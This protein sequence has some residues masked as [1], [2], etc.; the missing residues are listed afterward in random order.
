[1]LKKSIYPILAIIVGIILSLSYL[2]GVFT[3]LE[4]FLEDQLFQSKTINSNLVILSIDNDSIQKIGQWPWPRE[5]F[6]KLLENLNAAPPKA[7]AID[8]IFAEP[9]RISTYD[10]TRLGYVLEHIKYPVILA[11]E[12][13][14]YIN[15]KKPEIEKLLSPLTI[16]QTK[17][18]TLGLV[19]VIAD[20]DGVVRR[21][22]LSAKDTGTNKSYKALAYDLINKANFPIPKESELL[23][24][25]RIVY[26]GE[27]GSVRRI[28]F[29]RILSDKDAQKELEGKIVFIGA[30]ADNLHDSKPTPLSRGTE[31]PG[32]EIHANIANMLLSG[33]RL[34]PLNTF[35]TILWIILAVIIS[36]LFFVFVSRLSI[37]IGGNVFLGIVYLVAIIILFERG[38]VVNLIHIELSW[39]ISTII[40]FLYRFFIVEKE[41]REMKKTFG[42]YVSPTVLE[43]IVKNPSAVVL[44][45]EEREI[46]VLFS[47]IR[48]FTS[49]SEKTTP[50]EL[51]RILNTYFSA[52]TKKIIENDGVLDKYIGDAIM[53]FWG[54]PIPEPRQAD[55]AVK[56][57]L[58]MLEELEKLNRKL[59]SEG[60]P[61]IKIGIGIYTGKAVVGN[62]GSEHRFDYTAIGDTVNTAS[63]IEGL[64]KEYK[65][66][67][68]IGEGTKNKLT[69]N[70]SV[71]SLGTAN[72]KGKME[73]IKIYGV[74]R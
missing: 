22:P 54:A 65:T 38:I 23:P 34:I 48:G 20:S 25:N 27:T 13:S 56:A 74:K 6:A 28:P 4:Y 10:D 41:K 62:I 57:G 69:E 47:D 59:V 46:T 15:N 51:V 9:S 37:I 36:S 29:Y 68:I 61:E 19:N 64:T 1:M 52:I 55:K 44:G 43:Q 42:K 14:L 33:D 39:I 49:I 72:V 17:N 60:D 2:F 40:L 24:L 66:E 70:F 5:V 7:L 73:G 30:T 45:G 32:V 11:T 71:T 53:V 21:F 50:P 16:F 12:A 8:V 3:G 26:A 35:F 63:R 58:E 18:T 67:I 31:M